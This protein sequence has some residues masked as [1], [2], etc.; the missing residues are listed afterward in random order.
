MKGIRQI[1]SLLFCVVVLSVHGQK[2]R[3]YNSVERFILENGDQQK[4]MTIRQVNRMQA[5]SQERAERFANELS[6]YASISSANDPGRVL[7]QYQQQKAQMEQYIEQRNNQLMQQGFNSVERI[8]NLN[9]NSSEAQFYDAIGSAVNTIDESIK[10]KK[11]AEAQRQQLEAEKLRV[12]REIANDIISQNNSMITEYIGKAAYALN[13][14]EEDFYMKVAYYFNGHNTYIQNN[15]S[16]SSTQWASNPYSE[17]QQPTIIPNNLKSKYEKYTEA[18]KRKIALH[19][20]VN[21]QYPSLYEAAVKF[22]NGAIHENK[23]S[24]APYMLLAEITSKIDPSTAYSSLLIARK[25]D[26]R[27]FSQNGGASLLEE[28]R[29]IFR[30]NFVANANA[31]NIDAMQ[32]AINLGLHRGLTI[33]GKNTTAWAIEKDNANLLQLITNREVSD[34][35]RD[36]KKLAAVLAQASYKN[37]TKCTERLL[38]MGVDAD[39]DFRGTKP[40]YLASRAGS[41]E[42]LK[43]LYAASDEQST[44]DNFFMRPSNAPYAPGYMEW[45]L[46]EKLKAK[47]LLA[48]EPYV[49][50]FVKNRKAKPL[51]AT[52][53]SAAESLSEPNLVVALKPLAQAAPAGIA[54]D[55]FKNALNGPQPRV[56]EQLYLLGLTDLDFSLNTAQTT[57]RE[58]TEVVTNTSSASSRKYSS[59]IRGLAEYYV[60]KGSYTDVESA[61]A[62]L[63]TVYESMAAGREDY[64]SE[65]LANSSLE[66]ML[67]TESGQD[68]IGIEMSNRSASSQNM[69][70]LLL[71]KV[72]DNDLDKM[73]VDLSNQGTFRG[74]ERKIL[75]GILKAN[76]ERSFR[77][78]PELN[79]SYESKDEMGFAVIHQ[80][81][82]LGNTSLLD[83]L[84]KADPHL[85]NMEGAFGWTPMHIAVREADY[86]MMEYLYN[87]DAELNPKDDWGRTPKDIAKEY[88]EVPGQGQAYDRI[89]KFL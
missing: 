89:L 74:E 30:Q 80:I 55:V 21:D 66:I 86:D 82:Y 60:E 39:V 9:N 75:E 17:P 84:L 18:A 50:Y 48:A 5:A 87:K 19:H 42:S 83:M 6:N 53:V 47:D 7:Q 27:K 23:N 56:A 36:N 29:E 70:N 59:G 44:Y 35:G 51:L 85:V 28:Q 81:T 32:Q 77:R 76:A 46:S 13:P 37:A 38:R 10:A 11:A 26:E 58:V 8:S 24:P 3:D 61:E 45:R 33:E 68:L 2:E 88:A 72:I 22:A 34:N 69:K 49:Q 41:V 65:E 20:K 31:D 78:L 4:S 14:D 79:L 12:M 71:A 73:L 64:T 25:I 52:V 67:R 15:F 40:I 57:Q 63:R 54:N 16:T 1:M 43:V 62:A